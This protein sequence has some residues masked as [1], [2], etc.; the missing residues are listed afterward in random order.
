MNKSKK[1][2]VFLYI[3]LSVLLVLLLVFF[4]MQEVQYKKRLQTLAEQSSVLVEI[5]PEMQMQQENLSLVAHRG[6]TK[7]A[8][9]N[10]LL[11]IRD[12]GEAGFWGC[13]FDIR[14]TADGQWVLMHDETLLRTLGVDAIVSEST[15]ADLQRY[16]YGQDEH[17]LPIHIP[18]LREALLLCKSYDMMA[19]V[20]V[21]CAELPATYAAEIYEI[22]KICGMEGQSTVI[23][24]DE[25]FSACMKAAAPHVFS[26]LLTNNLSKDT[27]RFAE[28]NNLGLDV[29][30]QVPKSKEKLLQEAADKG[31][32]YSCWTVND[33]D[34]IYN[35]HAIGVRTFTTDDVMPEAMAP[36]IK[37]KPWK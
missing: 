7:N 16:S 20:E 36:I 24:F 21:K 32:L 22:L 25:N 15:Y 12:A 6:Y 31:L 35:L 11:S 26:A 18:T 1:I 27:I 28:D 8:P 9:E 2:K 19:Y 14:R 13:E 5:T 34:I 17:D 33:A 10:T 29:R 3:G 30:Y 23:S 4:N 37:F